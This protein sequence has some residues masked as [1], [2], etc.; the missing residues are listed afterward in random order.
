[1]KSYQEIKDIIT[2]QLGITDLKSYEAWSQRFLWAGQIPDQQ[3]RKPS[4]EDIDLLS[5]DNIDNNAFWRIA[6]ELFQTDPVANCQGKTPLS[7]AEAN[8]ENLNIYH[9]D[10]IT[11][12]INVAYSKWNALQNRTY[13]LLEIGP[14][15]GAFREWLDKQG[16]WEYYGA[17]VYPR[18]TGVDATQPNG[19]LDEIT[20][21]RRY[22]VVVACN[23]F[24]HLSV[25]Q[26]IH[27]YRDIQKC[28]M[29]QGH[30][31]VNMMV[32][33]GRVTSHRSEYGAVYCRHYGQLTLIQRRAEIESDLGRFFALDS[34]VSRHQGTWLTFR[35]T[36]K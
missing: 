27:Y 25:N 35:C 14:G 7:V 28:L 20:L 19:L 17:D 9:L 16:G 6:E 26:R 22:A 36:H 33:D 11:G 15:Y 24:Q 13:P 10:G 34:V 29:P 32:D 21:N 1:M 8:K 12:F 30:F 23:V 31:I 3:P 18:I 5:P 2:N 4:Q